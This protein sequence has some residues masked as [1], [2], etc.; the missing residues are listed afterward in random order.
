MISRID[1]GRKVALFVLN[2]KRGLIGSTRKT[3][4]SGKTVEIAQP[5][6]R[7]QLVTLRWVVP[8][9]AVV[10]VVRNVPIV[11]IVVNVTNQRNV[12]L[13]NARESVCGDL[14]DRH[15]EKRGDLRD[16]RAVVPA[17]T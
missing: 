5:Q 10:R 15:S 9:V 14:R 12:R 16:R 11:R 2:R 7:E 17:A 4:M 3:G 8:K 6:P 13:N 1:T